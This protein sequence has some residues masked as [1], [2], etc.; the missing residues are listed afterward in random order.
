[1]GSKRGNE[2]DQRNRIRKQSM[3][4]IW[5]TARKQSMEKWRETDPGNGARKQSWKTEQ[6]KGARN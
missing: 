5:K 1:L 6:G 4:R 2:T 3:E